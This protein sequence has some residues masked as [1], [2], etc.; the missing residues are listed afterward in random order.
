MVN[1]GKTFM[2]TDLLNKVTFLVSRAADWI[3]S[4]KVF[5]SL[6]VNLKP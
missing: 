6:V 3:L 5:I 4:N 1:L 2:S